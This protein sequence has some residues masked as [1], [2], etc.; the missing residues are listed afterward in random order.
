[1]AGPL[2]GTDPGKSPRAPLEFWP[3]STNNRC[4]NGTIWEGRTRPEAPARIPYGVVESSAWCGWG[5]GIGGADRALRREIVII[6]YLPD[7][8]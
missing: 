3:G 5:R 2:P 7:S 6:A 8:V 1:M 4:V